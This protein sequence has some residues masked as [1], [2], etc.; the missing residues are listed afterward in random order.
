LAIRNR[1][2]HD[3]W[4]RPI[5]G[6]NTPLDGLS[7]GGGG[8]SLRSDG[9]VTAG[10]GLVT[11]ENLASDGSDESDGKNQTYLQFELKSETQKPKANF[12]EPETGGNESN[13]SPNGE[14][15]SQHLLQPSQ[16][17]SFRHHNTPLIHHVSSPANTLK[18]TAPSPPDVAAQILQCQSWV[19]AVD[20]MDAVSAA[21][22]KERAVV[23]NSALKHFSFDERQHLVRLLTA[24][25]QQFP[26][27]ESAYDWL[28]ASSWKLK[29]KAITLAQGNK[30][31][32]E[33]ANE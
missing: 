29:E 4:S 25:I 27:D 23:Y 22:N 8:S 1:D 20:A 28:P 13:P 26:Q 18:S 2:E 21:I 3:G 16:D 32:K 5:T 12:I 11:A 17:S 15:L 9:L 24:H 6:N 7:N 33:W 19:A 31:G 10:D 14:V 30:A